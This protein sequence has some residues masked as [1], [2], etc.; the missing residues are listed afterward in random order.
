M[1]RHS[2]MS[3]RVTGSFLSWRLFVLMLLAAARS[4]S[5]PRTPSRSSAPCVA[6]S[7]TRR[8][9][10][11]LRPL[12]WSSTSRPACRAASKPTTRVVTRRRTCEPGTYRVEIVTTSFKK[13]EQ[14]GVVVRTGGVARVDARLEI[15]TVAET[16]TVSAEALNNLVTDSPSVAVG[17]DAQQLRDLPRNGR[18]MQ[19][20]LL[21][22]PN[23]LGGSDD[24]QFLGGR[25]YGVSYVQDGQ[26][27]T[28]AIFG[29]VG[30]SA[31]GLDAIA[32]IQVLSNSYS[33]EYGGLAGVV[34]TTK[35]GGNNHHGSAF[36]DFNSD[37]PERTD[38]QPEAVGSR[39]RRPERRHARAPLGRQP[40]RPDLRA[41][42]PS[43]S[44]TTRDRP[45]QEIYGGG[46][47]NVPDGRH[48][49]RRLLRRELHRSTIRSP[50]SR[51]QAT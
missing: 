47:A 17:L 45:R 49:R 24:I 3:A 7:P 19:S 33:A 20:F 32:E 38:L 46:R 1:R 10:A 9:R 16:V 11:S 41:T 40:G 39:A 22:N 29:T 37:E 21:L 42:R 6:P 12:S 43:S 5:S 13:F 35:R 30:N 51:F 14:T 50:A 27:S 31:P 8:E 28:N 2:F 44:R 4:P 18:D 48:A 34:V 23:V 25:T 15:G 26:A 36:Y